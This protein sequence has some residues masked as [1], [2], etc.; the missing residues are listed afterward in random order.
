MNIELFDF[1]DRKNL[2]RFVG[3]LYNQFKEVIEDALDENKEETISCLVKKY[4]IIGLSPFVGTILRLYS[5]S[6]RLV[7]AYFNI[8]V[9]KELASF[10]LNPDFNIQSDAYETLKVKSYYTL[11]YY[12]GSVFVCKGG[13]LSQI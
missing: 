12:I 3:D 13:C 5:K 2:E 6:S 7:I 1:E 10:V 11:N 4:N 9:L 8:E